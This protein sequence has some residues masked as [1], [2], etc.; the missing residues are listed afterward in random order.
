MVWK[1]RESLGKLQDA[2][3]LTVNA[4]DSLIVDQTKYESGSQA[5][6]FRPIADAIVH[7]L[8]TELLIPRVGSG[9]V[10]E[11]GARLARAENLRR[12]ISADQLKQITEAN[13]AV[14]WVS[15]DITR[16]RTTRLRN[17]LVNT[18]GIEEIDGEGF[19]RKVTEE[20]LKCQIDDWVR[21]FYE[22]LLDQQAIRRQFWFNTKPIIR[23]STGKHVV[24]KVDG[25]PNAYLPSKDRTEF[26]TVKDA[27]CSSEGSL[28]LLK[29]L[30]LKEPDPIDGVIHNILPRYSEQATEFPAEFDSDIDRIMWRC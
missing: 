22:F 3:F 18:I 10:S 29:D 30:G 26:P 25:K 16:E 9:H 6:M 5:S 11:N 12:L 15:G 20:F 2:N 4:I 23:L 13:E 21:E 28:K 27:V 17:F 19:V 8:Q 24:P 7:A 1:F 14:E